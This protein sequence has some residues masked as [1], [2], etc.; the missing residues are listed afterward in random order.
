MKTGD[1]VSVFDG[2]WSMSLTKGVLQRT[3]GIALYGRRFRVLAV[4]GTYPTDKSY[5]LQEINN[6]LLVD[7]DNHDFVLFTQER[8]CRVTAPPAEDTAEKD[9]KE[10]LISRHIKKVVL[11]LC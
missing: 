6:T 5:S 7:V 1:T 8:F 11:T 4:E 9:T 10:I 3:S 2:S